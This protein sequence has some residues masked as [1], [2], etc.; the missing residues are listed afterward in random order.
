[1]QRR[2]GLPLRRQATLLQSTDNMDPGDVPAGLQASTQV[3]EDILASRPLG[4]RGRYTFLYFYIHA[5]LMYCILY[6]DSPI[7]GHIPY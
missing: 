3:E 6:T 2:H 5:L 1:M 4:R 7:Q